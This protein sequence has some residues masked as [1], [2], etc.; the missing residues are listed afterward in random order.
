M[1]WTEVAE[2]FRA[3]GAKNLKNMS[4]KTLPVKFCLESDG[5]QAGSNRLQIL[6]FGL[7]KKIT[8]R[9]PA[10]SDFLRCLCNQD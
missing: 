8:D 2:H 10:T 9:C 7:I 3:C 5:P 6:D 4:L 1:H